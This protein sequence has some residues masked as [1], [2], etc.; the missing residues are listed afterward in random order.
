MDNAAIGRGAEAAIIK[1]L[2]WDIVVDGEPLHVLMVYLPARA[3]ELN[4]IEPVFHI[5]VCR[6]RYFRYPLAGLC[7]AAAVCQ[8]TR[9]LN[10]ITLETV[11]KG[12]I[13]CGH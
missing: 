7:N 9:V 2:L 5:M 11:I 1:D 4:P 12:N 3:L 6:I 10:E 13:H 8:T